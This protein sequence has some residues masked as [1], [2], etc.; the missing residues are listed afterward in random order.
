MLLGRLRLGPGRRLLDL[1]SGRGWPGV[2]LA[3][4][5]GCD[6]VLT[7]VPVHA[8]QEALAAARNRALT[9]CFATAAAG[10]EAIPFRPQT[11][12]SVVHCDVFC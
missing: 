7:D 4:K 11:F 5:S 10:G 12:D 8:P 6:V 9:G 1:G 3:E 2:Y